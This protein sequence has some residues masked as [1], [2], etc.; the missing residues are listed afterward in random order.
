M[1]GYVKVKSGHWAIGDEYRFDTSEKWQIANQCYSDDISKFL[2]D[3]RPGQKREVRR[4]VT[5]F[6]WR[7]SSDSQPT[8]YDYPIQVK[9]LKDEDNMIIVKA[10]GL[11]LLH[12]YLWSHYFEPEMPP[13][14]QQEIDDE[15]FNSWLKEINRSPHSLMVTTLH[16]VWH[17]AL[18]YRDGTKK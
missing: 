1:K 2:A 10:E 7:K 12:P 11:V 17:A 16:E 15:A 14:S 8:A 18:A 3:N 13:K 9:F 5:D 4:G 6:T